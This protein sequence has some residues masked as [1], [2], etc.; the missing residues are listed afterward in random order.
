MKLLSTSVTPDLK[1]LGPKFMEVFDATR[2]IE[3]LGKLRKLSSTEVLAISK[4]RDYLSQKLRF[5][6][7]ELQFFNKGF[8][9]RGVPS[10]ERL[11]SVLEVRKRYSHVQGTSIVPK[12][13]QNAVEEFDNLAKQIHLREVNNIQKLSSKSFDVSKLTPD[14]VIN[15]VDARVRLQMLARPM[16]PRQAA[17]VARVDKS[18]TSFSNTRVNILLEMK[19]AVSLNNGSAITVRTIRRVADANEALAPFVKAGLLSPANQGVARSVI[20]WIMNANNLFVATVVALTKKLEPKNIP[21]INEVTPQELSGVL[22]AREKITLMARRNLLSK[23]H[24]PILDALDKTLKMAILFDIK[25]IESYLASRTHDIASA[26]SAK[27]AYARLV[28]LERSGMLSD[29]QKKT[30]LMFRNA[31]K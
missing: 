3:A 12:G 7:T 31:Q 16:T 18:I 2:R 19:K 17:A 27:Q 25:T 15:L 14:K 9:D 10:V 8:A 22:F 11:R 20:G 30:V 5:D 28:L 26:D 21:K 1:A 23:Q 4:A 24:A 6:S 13:M 29:G